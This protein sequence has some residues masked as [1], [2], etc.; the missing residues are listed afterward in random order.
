MND[1]FALHTLGSKCVIERRGEGQKTESEFIIWGIGNA[2]ELKWKCLF[3][4]SLYWI[5]SV[6]DW[7]RT[8]TITKKRL[9]CLCAG[10]C[11][12]EEWTRAHFWAQNHTIQLN[13][14]F[15]SI[16]PLTL[17]HT[18]H[19]TSVCFASGAHLN[20]VHGELKCYAHVKWLYSIY[21]LTNLTNINWRLSI[22]ATD[23]GKVLSEK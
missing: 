14:N 9:R 12:D 7:F 6:V 5:C 20:I 1:G 23:C 19:T 3:T 16:L 21:I 8:T 4:F 2:V 17:P 11:A 22:T 13:S 15:L 10:G 18:Q